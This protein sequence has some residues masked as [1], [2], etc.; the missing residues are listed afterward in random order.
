MAR[1]YSLDKMKH[2]DYGSYRRRKDHHIRENTFYTH[3]VHKVGRSIRTHMD[4]MMQERKSMLMFPL[5]TTEWKE[6]CINIIDT[7]GMWTYV[8]VEKRGA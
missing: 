5:T 1:D 3:K 6:H 2:R 7:P 8:E 4:W